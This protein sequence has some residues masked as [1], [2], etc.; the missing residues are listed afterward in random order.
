[1]RNHALAAALAA[2]ALAAAAPQALG[3]ATLRVPSEY[4]SI[5]DALDAAAGGD[6]V[7]VAPGTYVAREATD[8]RFRGKAVTVRSEGGPLVTVLDSGRSGSVFLLDGGEPVGATVEGFTITGANRSGV[9]VTRSACT[10]R[11]CIIEDNWNGLFGGGVAVDGGEVVLIN[12]I[13][14]RN[15]AGQGAGVN[16][17]EGSRG[18]LE[19]CTLSGNR[20]DIIG[21]GGLMA[22]TGSTVEMIGCLVSGNQAIGFAGSSAGVRIARDSF[23]SLVNCVVEGNTASGVAAGVSFTNNGAGEVINCTISGNSAAVDGAGLFVSV[24]GEQV[25]VANTIV[26]GNFPDAIRH[27]DGDLQVRYSVV[28]GGW[29][30]EGNQAE[31]PMLQPDWSLGETSAAIDAGDNLAV[32]AGVLVDFGGSRRFADDIAVPDTGVPGGA[33]GRRVVDIG[34]VERQGT[35]CYHDCNGDGVLDFFDFLCFQNEF[36]AGTPYGDCDGSGVHDFFDFLCFQD[37]FAG[38]CP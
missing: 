27:D 12:C 15:L 36:A 37:E 19:G 10:V 16:L 22:D 21:G 13:I 34:A 23:G 20:T 9:Q 33:G 31:N 2:L 6:T 32:P 18:R 14:D 25:R 29:P 35:A 30:G 4:R 3:Q 1:M 17:W 8:I 24:S 28:E 5:Q 11:D 26:W 38:G 7:L